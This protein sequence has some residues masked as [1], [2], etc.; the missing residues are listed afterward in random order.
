VKRSLALSIP[1]MLV[2]A[3]LGHACS[4]PELANKMNAVTAASMTAFAKHPE[5]DA[6]RQDRVQAI[7]GRYAELRNETGGAAAIDALCSEYDE[8]LAVYK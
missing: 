5:E 6:A 4:G 2:S 7:I 3:G 8:L 1:I